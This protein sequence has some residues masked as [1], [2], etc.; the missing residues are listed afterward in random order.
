MDGLVQALAGAGFQA[1]K[2]KGSF[3][4]YVKAPRTAITKAGARVEF[5]NAEAVSQWLIT[6]KLISTAILPVMA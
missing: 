4:L 1:R 3:F 6:E 5:P 2:P